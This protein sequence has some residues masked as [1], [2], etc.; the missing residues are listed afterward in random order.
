M[1]LFS[2][3]LPGFDLIFF[4]LTATQWTVTLIFFNILE[5]TQKYILV[6]TKKQKFYSKFAAKISVYRMCLQSVNPLLTQFAIY[7]FLGKKKVHT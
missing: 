2:Q 3:L 7:K 1:I 5:Y 4:T 6:L